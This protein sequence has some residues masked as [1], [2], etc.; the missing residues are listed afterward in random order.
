MDLLVEPSS[1]CSGWQ[2][3][4]VDG[5]SE[6]RNRKEQ[7]EA[8]HQEGMHMI[9]WNALNLT[10]FKEKKKTLLADFVSFL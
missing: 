2:I 5:V 3:S 10:V 4:D 1:N 8:F 6:L 9:N 7:T